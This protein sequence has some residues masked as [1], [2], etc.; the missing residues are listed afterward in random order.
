M[1][2][3]IPV[4]HC[5]KVEVVALPSKAVTTKDGHPAALGSIVYFRFSVGPAASEYVVVS[6]HALKETGGY[7]IAVVGPAGTAG[8]LS[9]KDMVKD[10]AEWWAFYKKRYAP[11]IQ[12]EEEPNECR[13]T[14]S[15]S[16]RKPPTD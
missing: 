9:V 13:K 10:K 2:E 4:N 3:T 16:K 12:M 11:T 7:K 6:G 5:P 8:W 1:A 15:R 14:A